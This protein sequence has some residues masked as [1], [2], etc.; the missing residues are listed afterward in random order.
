VYS[1]LTKLRAEFQKLLDKKLQD[2]EEV[3]V[4]ACIFVGEVNKYLIFNNP[5]FIVPLKQ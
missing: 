4:L 3:K 5:Q 1:K 2:L